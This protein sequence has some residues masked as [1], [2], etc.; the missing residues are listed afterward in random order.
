MSFLQTLINGVTRL[1]DFLGRWIA[2]LI[3]AMSAL[4]LIEV[5]CRYVF[6]APTVWTTEFAQFLF[7]IYSIMAGGYVMANRGHVN[8]DLLYSHFSPRVQAIIDVFTSAVFFIFILAFLYFGSSMAWESILSQE[9]T[10]SAWNPP[11]WPV[12][13]FIPVAVFLV[14]LQG[15]VKLMRDIAVAINPENAKVLK[16]GLDDG[17]QEEQQL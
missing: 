1:N 15:I 10:Y 16:D 2:H 5:I 12:K 6:D 8:V 4:L 11:V 7:A 14:L 17:Q 3:F 13:A 9:T